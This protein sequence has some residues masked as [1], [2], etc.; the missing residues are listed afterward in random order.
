LLFTYSP[1]TAVNPPAYFAL[2][3]PGKLFI[4]QENELMTV[5]DRISLISAPPKATPALLSAIRNAITTTSIG[6]QRSTTGDSQESGK[7]RISWNDKKAK[8]K[9]EGWVYDGVYRF[10]LDGLRR[11][12]VG[13]VKKDAVE[14]YVL[15]FFTYETRA[16][17]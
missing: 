7:K 10:W 8:I 9:V 15:P 2:S 4:P 6:H 13:G 12:L 17:D 3:F 1:N 5:P 14:L 11:R 16:D